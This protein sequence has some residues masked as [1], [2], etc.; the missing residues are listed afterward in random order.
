MIGL[1]LAERCQ[2]ISNK[3]SIKIST[4]SLCQIYKFNKIKRKFIKLTK[5]IP[6]KSKAYALSGKEYSR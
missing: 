5:V 1:S 6:D 2:I 4:S 3:F